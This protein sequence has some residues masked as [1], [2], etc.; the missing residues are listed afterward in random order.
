[1]DLPGRLAWIL[2]APVKAMALVQ[3]DAARLERTGIPGDRTFAVVDADLRLVNAKRVGA[4][5]SVRPSY[6][7]AVGRL[8]LRF[9]DG[10][11]VIDDAVLGEPTQ[12][13]FFGHP[14][15]VRLVEGP[16]TDA[17]SAWA[18]QVLRLVAPIGDGEGLDR[19]PSASLLSTTALDAV[20]R[21]GGATEPLDGRRFRMTFGV[22]GTEPFAEDAWIGR[23]VRVGGAVVRPVGNVGRCAVTTQDPDTGV[24]TFDTLKVLAR[25]RGD[26]PTTEA[27]PCG[28]WA[29]VVTPGDL[30]L[31]DPVGPIAR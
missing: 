6:E 22:E 19:G 30:R 29:E 15:P 28:V 7:P 16:F 14:R 8:T 2:V 24:P 9:P 31:G 25:M 1:M 27:L 10:G 23:E 21:G 4:L 26:L 20:A 5:V 3:L 13:V 12:A 11:T 17:L 18:G